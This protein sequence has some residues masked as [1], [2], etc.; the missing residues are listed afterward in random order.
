MTESTVHLSMRKASAS[1]RLP[2]NP[3]LALAMTGFTA[4]L[5]ET[6]PPACCPASR[7]GWV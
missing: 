7:M 4:V 1:D 3:L 5:T 2:L 6:L